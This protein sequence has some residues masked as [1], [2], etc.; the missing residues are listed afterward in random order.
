MKLVISV[1]VVGVLCT[2]VHGLALKEKT[3]KE[4]DDVV[5]VYPS[6]EQ[7]KDD[8]F[9]SRK[10]DSFASIDVPVAQPNVLDY[11]GRV[12]KLN[13]CQQN[14][15]CIAQFSCSERPFDY[16][17]S[18]ESSLWAPESPD[19][20]VAWS[21]NAKTGKC[22]SFYY[23][24]CDGSL[25]TFKTQMECEN[26]CEPKGISKPRSPAGIMSPVTDFFKSVMNKV[27]NIPN[28]IQERLGKRRLDSKIDNA[29]EGSQNV[30]VKAELSEADHNKDRN[31]CWVPIFCG[32]Q[33]KVQNWFQERIGSRRFHKEK[34][35]RF[36]QPPQQQQ[37]VPNFGRRRL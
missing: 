4:K 17:T 8:K 30:E 34:L 20:G 22:Q 13:H 6:K 3:L 1:I 24:G 29:P 23:G 26:L 35:L 33:K 16:G 10:S 5:V 7:M 9:Q 18:C 12:E 37:H 28:W 31:D 14:P 21:F 15:A 32:M 2:S 25:N 36:P 27:N 11:N 19:F